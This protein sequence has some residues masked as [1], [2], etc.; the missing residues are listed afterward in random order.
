[1]ADNGT[2][3]FVL[4][5]QSSFKFR[6]VDVFSDVQIIRIYK[7]HNR[8]RNPGITRSWKRSIFQMVSAYDRS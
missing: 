5:C 2:F 3:S 7:M 4:L 8:R 1:M 6:F